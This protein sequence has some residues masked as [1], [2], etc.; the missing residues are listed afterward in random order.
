ML[1]LLVKYDLI[2]GP[3]QQGT[4]LLTIE[5]EIRAIRR[6][7]IRRMFP[8]LRRGKTLVFARRGTIAKQTLS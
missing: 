8:G 6:A 7:S 3:R 1:T 5:S 2:M 4:A